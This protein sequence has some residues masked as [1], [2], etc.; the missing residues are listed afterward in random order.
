MSKKVAGSMLNKVVASE[1]QAERDNCNF[2]KEELANVFATPDGRALTE[3]T[4]REMAENPGFENTHKFY[5][6]SPEEIQ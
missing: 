2:D 1:L 4:L 5:E 6:Y 3:K